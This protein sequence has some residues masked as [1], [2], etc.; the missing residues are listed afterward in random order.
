MD[1]LITMQMCSMAKCLFPHPRPSPCPPSPVP[2]TPV[3]AAPPASAVINASATPAVSRATPAHCACR[4]EQG[5]LLPPPVFAPCT[6]L[7]VPPPGTQGQTG[8]QAPGGKTLGP[9]SKGLCCCRAGPEG[10]AQHP[11]P[12]RTG[13][14]SAHTVFCLFSKGKN[15]DG[16][17]PPRTGTASQGFCF[18]SWP[19]VSDSRAGARG[20][21]RCT[22]L[23]ATTTPA[24]PG[25][26]GV[27][28]GSAPKI[29]NCCFRPRRPS[30]M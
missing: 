24:R 16:L 23:A 22:M 10:P 12:L 3:P 5:P 13:E 27:G 8:R 30:C 19:C 2:P 17:S 28:A 7:P 11:Q 26:A 9:C 20:P 4:P 21:A 18:L 15:I 14:L 6:E 29:Q 25:R 1:L